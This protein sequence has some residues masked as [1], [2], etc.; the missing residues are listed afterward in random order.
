MK[1]LATVITCLSYENFLAF[2]V[3]IPHFIFA[4]P[5]T[6]QLHLSFEPTHFL[7]LNYVATV[8]WFSH[9]CLVSTISFDFLNRF[10]VEF[11]GNEYNLYII[12]PL[13]ERSW[14]VEYMLQAC[15]LFMHYFIV[16]WGWGLS[17]HCFSFYYRHWRV[18]WGFSKI[19]PVSWEQ[20]VLYGLIAGTLT[21]CYSSVAW[22]SVSEGQIQLNCSLKANSFLN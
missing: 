2:S 21:D 15:F 4:L 9:K 12:L 16:T 14:K 10:W 5:Q 8:F 18:L 13:K 19:L 1:D 20:R 6:A 17:F 11:R 7:V 22:T 3:L